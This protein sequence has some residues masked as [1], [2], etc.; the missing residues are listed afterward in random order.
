M[1][2]HQ[3]DLYLPNELVETQRWEWCAVPPGIAAGILG[4]ISI[5]VLLVRLFGV[6]VWFK[7]FA[8]VLTTLG[9]VMNAVTCICIFVQVQPVEAFWNPFITT[10]VTSWNPRIVQN[11][12]F[13]A[14][15]EYTFFRIT[16]R[17][18]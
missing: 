17:P 1:G 15:C 11:M 2:K 9:V 4:R 12:M 13:S 6:H 14:Q 18:S 16:C 8:I 3:A 10:T 5:C 7:W